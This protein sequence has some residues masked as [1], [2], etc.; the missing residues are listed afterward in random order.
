[1]KLTVAVCFVGL[2]LLG[3]VVSWQHAKSVTQE[4][5]L[6]EAYAKIEELSKKGSDDSVLASLELQS[7]CAK[8]SAEMFKSSSLAKEM[9]SGFASHYS[10][11]L[12]RCFMET[13]HTSTMEG[14]GWTNTEINDPFE[15]RE[16]ARYS[17]RLYP[18]KD[19]D[20]NVLWCKVTVPGAEEKKCSS[21][22]SSGPSRQCSPVN[23]RSPGSS[24]RRPSSGETRCNCSRT[25]RATRSL[26]AGR[27]PRIRPPGP[28]FGVRPSPESYRGRVL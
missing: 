9:I 12:G 4:K 26:G 2:I 19:A 6:A 27:S 24:C 1:M 7:R 23:N 21:E 15:R 28:L 10:R 5:R 17:G 20:D 25:V 8:Q 11:K 22:Q 3:G 13:F 18:K 14:V 16:F